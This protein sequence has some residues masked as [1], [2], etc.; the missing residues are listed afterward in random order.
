MRLLNFCGA[1]CGRLD[2]RLCCDR[3]FL[4]GRR[5]GSWSVV[6][7]LGSGRFPASLLCLLDLRA[8]VRFRILI[9]AMARV[10]ARL[11]PSNLL[12]AGAGDLL[13]LVLR[14]AILF[15]AR[16]GARGLLLPRRGKSSLPFPDCLRSVR[17]G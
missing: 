9:L 13:R 3:N 5:V 12:C 10:A 2:L 14:L 7:S 17:G 4:W 1:G 16:L 6:R 11:I 8:V 15:L